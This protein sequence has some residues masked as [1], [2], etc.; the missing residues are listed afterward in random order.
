MSQTMKAT[1]DSITSNPGK[2]SDNAV[3][4]EGY[5][6]Q[7]IPPTSTS[8]SYYLLMSDYGAIIKVNT[9]ESAPEITKKYHV[10]GI[11]YIDPVSREPFISEKSK[12]VLNQEKDKDDGSKGGNTTLIVVV[13]LMIVLLVG[14]LVYL[15]MKAKKPTPG[16]ASPDAPLASASSSTPQSDFKTIRLSPSAPK[17]MKFI[18]GELVLMSG[19]DKGK[20]FKIAGYPTA[21]GSIVSIGRELVNGERSYAH[22]QIDNKFQTVSRKQAEI[23]SIGDQLFVKNL[24][25]TNLSQVDGV[26][27]KPGEKKELKPNSTLKTGELE[28]KYKV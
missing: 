7:Y 11:V 21:E 3:E 2:Y 10:T 18:R 19:E 28:F 16:S 9:S 22:I 23:I 20:S 4:V 15:Q 12:Y 17:T 8:T 14:A 25:E 13:S 5:V 26:E 1:I 27:L 24:S 6:K